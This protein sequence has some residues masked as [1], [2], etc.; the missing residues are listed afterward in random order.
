LTT[1]VL[2]EETGVEVYFDDGEEEFVPPTEE[3]LKKMEER[4][5]QSDKISAELGRRMLQG[6]GLYVWFNCAFVSASRVSLFSIF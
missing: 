4:R 6:W 2:T 5:K 3:E 1:E